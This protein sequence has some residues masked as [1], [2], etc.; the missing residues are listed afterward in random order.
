[1]R[2]PLASKRRLSRARGLGPGVSGW[3]SRWRICGGRVRVMIVD[4]A[5]R[6]V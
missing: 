2:R 4:G 1:M 5:E 6:G 3:Q